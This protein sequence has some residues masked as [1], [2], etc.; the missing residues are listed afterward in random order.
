MSERFT[1]STTSSEVNQLIAACVHYLKRMYIE[2][3]HLLNQRILFLLFD[4]GSDLCVLVGR[5]VFATSIANLDFN[6]LF[7]KSL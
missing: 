3:I 2:T 6:N 1:P 7:S 5:N 4:T